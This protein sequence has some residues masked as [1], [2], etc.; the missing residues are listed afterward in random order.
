M[1]FENDYVKEILA[2]FYESD[3]AHLSL[4][5]LEAAGIKIGDGEQ[6]DQRFLFHLQYIIEEK[7]L[8]DE[9]GQSSLSSLGVLLS[10]AKHY[11]LAERMIRLT[12]YGLYKIA[13]GVDYAGR[14]S[15]AGW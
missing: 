5:D 14:D 9:N 3:M 11:Q 13:N 12:T 10:D 6:I 1:K 2:V 8:S 4:F 7:W 15:G